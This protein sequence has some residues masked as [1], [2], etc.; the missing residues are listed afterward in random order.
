M[1]ADCPYCSV[2]LM[3]SLEGGVV[4]VPGR[5]RGVCMLRAVCAA[6]ALPMKRQVQYVN[7]K[8]DP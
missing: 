1:S 8:G 4:S 2:L 3:D 5:P 6:L 7:V